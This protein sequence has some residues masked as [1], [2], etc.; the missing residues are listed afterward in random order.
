MLRGKWLWG[1]G[2]MGC[3]GRAKGPH[4]PSMSP[5]SP[6]PRDNFPQT[7]HTL[8]G[9]LTMPP[10]DPEVPPTSS[11]PVPAWYRKLRSQAAWPNGKDFVV[12]NQV[13][14]KGPRDQ[15]SRR[16]GHAPQ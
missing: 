11:K 4:H 10:R 8:C 9:Q 14:E 2:T 7:P 5:V 15:S 16:D 13:R 1:L 3:Y 12:R 6:P